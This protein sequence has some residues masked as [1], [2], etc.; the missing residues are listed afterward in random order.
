MLGKR[1]LS[2]APTRVGLSK[3]AEDAFLYLARTEAACLV[4]LCHPGVLHV[5]Q[6]LD[7]TKATLPPTPLDPPSSCMSLL[8]PFIPVH[9]SAEYN[10]LRP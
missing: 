2:E 9:G 4:C 7:E 3:A 5:V 8:Q 10:H 1:T 6:V